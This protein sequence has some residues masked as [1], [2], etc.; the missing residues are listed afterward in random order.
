VKYI[1]RIGLIFLGLLLTMSAGVFIVLRFYE[2]EIGT[3][4]MKKLKGQITTQL[5]VQDVGL[6]FWKTF[7]NASVALSQVYVQDRSEQRDTLLYAEELYL[8]FNLW[9]VFRGTYRVDEVEINSGKLYLEVDTKGIHNWEVWKE[10]TGEVSNF[11]IELEEI[12]L[13]DTRVFYSNKPNDFLLDILAVQTTGN[14]NFSSKTMDVELAIDAFVE[15]LSGQGDVYL[16]KRIL[17]GDIGLSADLNTGKFVF[18]RSEI[19]CGDLALSVEGSL[20]DSGDGPMEF[21]TEIDDQLIED[22]W[23]VLPAT[24]RKSIKDY[25]AT[26]DFSAKAKIARGK[27]NEPVLVEAELEVDDGTLKLKEEGVALEDISTHLYF[28]R[29]GK[30]DQIRLHS[31]ACSLDGSNLQASGNITGF[32]EPML[33]MKVSAE[34]ELNDIRDLLALQQIEICEGQVSAEAALQGK[35]RYV[36]ADTSYNWRDILATGN[37]RIEGASLKMRNSNRLFSNMTADFTF[38]KQSAI[39]RQFSGIVNGGDFLLKGTL[40]NVI[41]FL[42]EPQARVFLDADL[43]SKVIDFTNLV[44]E[45]SST[46]AN[47][48]YE[49][50]FPALLDFKLNCSIEKFIF[51]KFEALNVKGMATLDEGTLVVDPVSF[52][53][54]GGSL[55]AQLM[56]DPIS[57]TAYRMNCLADLK[58]IHIDRVFTEFENFGQ[59]FIQDRHLKGI[60]HANVQFRAL[61]TN[62]LELPSDK[63]ESIIDVTIENG[64]L[65]DF[66]TLQEIADYLRNNKWVAP[67]VDEDRFAERMRNVKFS[68][69][70]NVIQIRNRVV[71]IP[72]MD[73]RSSAMDIS[74]KGTH[75]FDYAIDYA[76]GFNLRDLLVR[77]DKEWSESDDGLGKSMYISMK[78]TVDNPIYAVDRELAKEM[79]QEAMEAEKQ[80]VKALLKD[81]FGLFK[82]DESVGKFKEANSSSGESTITVDWEEDNSGKQ[83]IEQR[84]APKLKDKPT[85]ATQSPEKK[86]KTPKWLEEKDE[87]PM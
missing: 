37:A 50:L 55:N 5:E 54:A 73:V 23:A 4:A 7:P 29:G 49:L 8:K 60:A 70:K 65:N 14:G 31:F 80:N 76:V 27:I 33:D 66:E 77:K 58:G 18:R 45:E 24:L 20:E 41:P 71:T 30:K 69:L 87:R 78:G 12:S 62:A 81:E 40:N 63:I 67:F 47:S 82:K 22:A 16:E 13:M 35:L 21:Y 39:I 68:E 52:I 10:S 46:D 17:S 1:K 86:K 84:P 75:T 19:T 74:A 26:G 64:E 43:T 51:R 42:F 2:D 61:L 28:A 85:E 56:L 53:T 38:D 11:E 59:N 25:K 36:E 57:N 3:F 34:M 79:R 44:E 6:A 9:D 15:K 32:D 48:E 83:S 72:L